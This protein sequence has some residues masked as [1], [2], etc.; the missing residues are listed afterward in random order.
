[1]PTLSIKEIIHSN[2]N[3]DYKLQ[4][5]HFLRWGPKNFFGNKFSNCETCPDCRTGFFISRRAE[6]HAIFPFHLPKF[7]PVFAQK[8]ILGFQ[9]SSFGSYGAPALKP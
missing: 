4:G 7:P 8:A 3:K 9:A 6:N 1:M 2:K 5:P